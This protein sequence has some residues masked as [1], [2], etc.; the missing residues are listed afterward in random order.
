[1]VESAPPDEEPKRD[2]RRTFPWEAVGYLSAGCIAIVMAAMISAPTSTQLTG[3]DLVSAVAF[4]SVALQAPISAKFAAVPVQLVA[5]GSLV[6]VVS[7]IAFPAP[8]KIG[9]VARTI[10]GGSS[11]GQASHSLGQEAP[12]SSCSA[13]NSA[14]I[15]ELL[16]NADPAVT[17]S[18][19]FSPD[20]TRRVA[21]SADGSVR[22]LDG[23]SD[24]LFVE[25]QFTSPARYAA[26]S[27]DGARIVAVLTD[28][29]LQVLDAST[30]KH[31]LEIPVNSP[32][33]NAAFSPDGRFIAA[34]LNNGIG[35]V[36]DAT[37]GVPCPPLG[38]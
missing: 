5:K 20:R 28:G 6:L 35:R 10:L 22:V 9:P 12:S 19:T 23:S 14:Q 30:G 18:V 11:L 15:A 13:I 29:P 16:H 32:A 31:L 8:S 25:D 4:G 1:V 38:K 3:L 36:W 2:T 7:V 27:P 34:Q 17:S 24:K 33:L 21:V 37:N 26:F